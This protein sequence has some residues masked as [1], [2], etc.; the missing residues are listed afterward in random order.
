MSKEYPEHFRMLLS[1]YSGDRFTIPGYMGQWTLFSVFFVLSTSCT[2]LPKFLWPILCC[3]PALETFYCCFFSIG[4]LRGS[5]DRVT[6]TSP[7]PYTLMIL[8]PTDRGTQ[9]LY[10]DFHILMVMSI[11]SAFSHGLFSLDVCLSW[12]L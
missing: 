8:S 10:L 4:I 3:F 2:S 1:Q 9:L 6:L 12:D 5:K 7:V 11:S